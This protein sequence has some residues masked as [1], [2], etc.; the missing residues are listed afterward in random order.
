M[1]GDIH[2]DLQIANPPTIRLSEHAMALN[3]RVHVF[4]ASPNKLDPLI[5]QLL[6]RCQN[7]PTC[8]LHRSEKIMAGCKM[9]VSNVHLPGELRVKVPGL[10]EEVRIIGSRPMKATSVDNLAKKCDADEH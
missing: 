10:L 6:L 1:D 4:D 7:M 5:P 3:Y 2:E 9:A 8:P